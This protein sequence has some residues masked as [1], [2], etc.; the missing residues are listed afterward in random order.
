MGDS[1]IVGKPL[2]VG[3]TEGDLEGALVGAR[4]GFL[5]G[6]LVDVGEFVAT[7]M[8]ALGE[9]L[10]EN[11]SELPP[12]SVPFLKNDDVV[13]VS[14]L[15]KTRK[16]SK[17]TPHKTII[18]TPNTMFPHVPRRDA[19]ASPTACDS[20]LSFLVLLVIAVSSTAMPF[21]LVESFWVSVGGC[22]AGD[23]TSTTFAF[24]FSWALSS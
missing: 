6:R 3:N 17:T 13:S 2:T 19:S 8:V 4:V 10:G 24:S 18:S 9:E 5:V 22:S 14:V 23:S 1:L 16:Y 21:P 7:V 12:P 20:S 11:E 15:L